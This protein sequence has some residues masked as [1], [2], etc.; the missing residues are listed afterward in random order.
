MLRQPQIAAP[1]LALALTLL[2]AAVA[3]DACAADWRPALCLAAV[4][5]AIVLVAWLV[6]RQPDPRP[7]AA[8][9]LGGLCC[10]AVALPQLTHAHCLSVESAVRV[11]G[12]ALATLGLAFLLWP[13]LTYCLATR[14]E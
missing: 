13:A 10:W 11:A 9:S 7:D 8:A 1:V 3:R 4:L 6:Y 14:R 5:I 12:A 2:F